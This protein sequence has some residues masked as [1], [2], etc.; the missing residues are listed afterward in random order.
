MLIRKA[1]ENRR[2]DIADPCSFKNK[3]QSFVPLSIQYLTS[4]S[5]GQIADTLD[6]GIF[7]VACLSDV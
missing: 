1:P 3:G 4:C 7:K 6:L 5:T 2:D